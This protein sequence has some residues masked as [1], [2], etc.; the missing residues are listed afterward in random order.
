[1]SRQGGDLSRKDQ[2][3]E[4]LIRAVPRMGEDREV[5]RVND[6]SGL[7]EQLRRRTFR[8]EDVRLEAGAI[9]VPNKLRQAGRSTAELWAMMYVQDRGRHAMPAE[10]FIDRLDAPDIVRRVERLLGVS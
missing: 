8:T 9:E 6:R 2:P 7:G 3:A 10:L 5:A 4:A 1:M